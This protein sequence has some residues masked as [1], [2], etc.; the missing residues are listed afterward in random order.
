[1]THLSRLASSSSYLLVG[2]FMKEAAH[3][4]AYPP[5]VVGDDSH[6]G[7]R[8]FTPSFAIRSLQV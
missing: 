6:P 7:V 4:S 8:T 1:V 3:G 2:L 5:M